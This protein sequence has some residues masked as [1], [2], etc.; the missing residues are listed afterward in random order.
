MLG[1]TAREA[2]LVVRMN[3]TPRDEVDTAIRLLHAANVE[4][5]GI[6][7]THWKNYSKKYEYRYS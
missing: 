5:C 3:E 2:L 1:R 4:I 6:V 7:L